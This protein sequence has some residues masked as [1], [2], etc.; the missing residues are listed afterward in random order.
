MRRNDNLGRILLGVGTAILI[1][2]YAVVYL[3]RASFSASQRM[4]G[5]SASVLIVA[6]LLKVVVGRDGTSPDSRSPSDEPRRP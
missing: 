6:I 3:N 1:S 2:I 5:L 4:V